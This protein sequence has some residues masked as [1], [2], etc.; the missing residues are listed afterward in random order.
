MPRR[1]ARQRD[2][3]RRQAPLGSAVELLRAYDDRRFR[4]RGRASAR[5]DGQFRSRSS[6][7][8]R[9]PGHL[10]G[11]HAHRP[12]DRDRRIRAQPGAGPGS[13]DRAK[14]P[15]DAARAGSGF[16]G[17]RT[18][19]RAADRGDGR[20]GGRRRRTAC[21]GACLPRRARY[22][23]AQRGGLAAIHDRGVRRPC[24]LPR[25]RHRRP[26][27]RD[28]SR[29]ALGAHRSRISAD[30]RRRG[31][32]FG[33][34]RRLGAGGCLRARRERRIRQADEDRRRRTHRG[35]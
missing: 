16:T 5:P 32:V 24:R 33:A 28:G 20:D 8:R 27:L 21:G 11:I 25:R 13:G 23:A 34:R 12:G 4:A 1:C 18:Q 26:L 3:P 10:P 31:A 17:R 6:E 9:R 22:A 7:H 29:S 14:Q 19:S 35:R 2:Q 15:V 30:R